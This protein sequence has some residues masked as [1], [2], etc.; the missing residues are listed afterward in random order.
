MLCRKS[1]DGQ[2]LHKVQE[3]PVGAGGQPTASCIN[4]ERK[5]AIGSKL[6][7]HLLSRCVGD[8]LG[9]AFVTAQTVADD[10]HPPE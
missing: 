3:C 5:G 7:P 4:S 1:Q 2:W 8:S 6:G 9:G 10:I